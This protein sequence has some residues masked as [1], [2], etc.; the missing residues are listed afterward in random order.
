MN[1]I[2]KIFIAGTCLFAIGCYNDS[3]EALYNNV[4]TAN[5]DT[6]NIT[7]SGKIKQ[8][9]SAN[10]GSCHNLTTGPLQ[11]GGYVLDNIAGLQAQGNK[12]MGDINQSPGF[13]A[14]P[15]GG[16]RLTPCDIVAIQHWV[17]RNFPQN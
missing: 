2:K 5:C 11:G 4:G 10:C 7:Y 16:N 6:T 3:Q 12:L 1:A 14:M 17:D 13:N 15:K 8:I 9:I